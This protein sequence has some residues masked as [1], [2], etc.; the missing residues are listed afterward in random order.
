MNL[1]DKRARREGKQVSTLPDDAAF[2]KV[3][4]AL[5]ERI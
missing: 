5:V 3:S 2:G 1:R 4:L